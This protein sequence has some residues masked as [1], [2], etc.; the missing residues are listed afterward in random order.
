MPLDK[1]MSDSVA[2]SFVNLTFPIAMADHSI[3]SLREA[4]AKANEALAHA[5]Q[6][7]A[8]ALNQAKAANEGRMR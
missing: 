8:D 4:L 1:H 7:R 2:F 5:I 3:E 6:E